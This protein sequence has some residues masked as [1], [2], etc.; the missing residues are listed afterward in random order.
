MSRNLNLVIK[1]GI[2]NSPI[3][4]FILV[5][6]R[7]WYARWWGTK[8]SW[9]KREWKND[10]RNTTILF[11][12]MMLVGWFIYAQVNGTHVKNDREFLSAVKAHHY[13]VGTAM[14]CN[15]N[16]GSKSTATDL[17]NGHNGMDKIREWQPC[18]VKSHAVDY[19]SYVTDN[20]TY[21]PLDMRLKK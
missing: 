18:T 1:I 16:V 9:E 20:G 2:T 12:V 15:V 11:V 17:N 21:S 3:P 19:S 6:I 7:R 8:S 4:H 14:E 5:P 13:E 10:N